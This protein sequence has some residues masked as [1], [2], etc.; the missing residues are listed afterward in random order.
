MNRELYDRQFE[1]FQHECQASNRVI[2]KA[3]DRLAV[4]DEDGAEHSSKDYSRDYL[5]HCCWAARQIAASGAGRHVDFGSYVYFAGILS[6][7]VKRVTFCDIR[8]LGT[9][10]PGLESKEADLMR[11][12]WATE[13]L[14]SVSCLHVLEHVGLGRYGDALDANGDLL[15]AR[16]LWR[17][18]APGGRLLIVLP[19][20]REPRVCFNAHRIYSRDQVENLLFPRAKVLTYETIMPTGLIHQGPEP[21]GDYTGCWV[22]TK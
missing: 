1:Q 10:I 18:L 3:G 22:F 14:P 5:A 7:F 16:E 12:P 8:A 4:L 15:A 17:V 2:P 19:T 13:A 11:I 6:A 21:Y 20:N 9:E